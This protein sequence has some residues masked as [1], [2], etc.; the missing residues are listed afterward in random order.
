MIS[1]PAHDKKFRAHATVSELMHGLVMMKNIV[2]E[3]IMG[4]ALLLMD[5]Q[6]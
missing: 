2:L 1:M 3:I 4:I 5:H 6:K